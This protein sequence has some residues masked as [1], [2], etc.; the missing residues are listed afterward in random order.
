MTFRFLE[1]V[2]RARRL[3]FRLIVEVAI[4]N[5]GEIE[6]QDAGRKLVIQFIIERDV[7]CKKREFLFH[8]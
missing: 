4:C 2:L 1:I 8:V 5:V 6:A 3:R 7:G